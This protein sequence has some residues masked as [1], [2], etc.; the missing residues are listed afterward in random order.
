M[1][2]IVM[3]ILVFFS[4]MAP[5]LS[6][7]ETRLQFGVYTSD[8]P[9]EM[10]R[11]FKPVLA[12]L[13]KLVSEKIGEPIKIKTEV[14]NTYEGGIQALVDGEIDFSR[15]GPASYV[16]AKEKNPDIDI[17]AME[18][19]NGG[20]TFKGIIC[21]HEESKINSI[22]DLKDTNFAFGDPHSTIGRY[23]AQSVLLDSGI[24]AKDL[25]S[26]KY[27][28]RHDKVGSSVS[29]GQYDAGALKESTFNKLKKN[30][31]NLRKLV[32][33][34]N[35]TKPWVSRSGLSE[36]L[37]T[38]LKESLLE[39]NSPEALKAIKKDGFVSGND[40]DYDSIRKAIN[41]N[42]QFFD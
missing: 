26:Y 7:A 3:Q 39:I 29:A 2:I 41:V 40:R 8:K 15:L 25:A 33:F 11:K 1:K 23:L 16:T 18:S 36:Q 38:V 27:L 32:E 37:K 9:S 12:V 5:V 13:E 4:L 35:V 21:V 20:K 17:L 30:G 19:V 6:R 22:Q 28:G 34:Q 14:F 24:K 42:P 10:V 31:A